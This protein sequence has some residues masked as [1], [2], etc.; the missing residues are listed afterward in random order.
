[1]SELIRSEAYRISK[2][3]EI[4]RFLYLPSIMFQ[5]NIYIVVL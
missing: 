5:S 2:Y 3:R 1:M 4:Q